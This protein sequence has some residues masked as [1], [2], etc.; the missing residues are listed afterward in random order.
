[1][2]GQSPYF[3]CKHGTILYGKSCIKCDREAQ[4]PAPSAG[5][6]GSIADDL[7]VGLFNDA[8]AEIILSFF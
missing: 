2:S 1:M 3:K 7:S 5:S 4:P 6:T 8:E